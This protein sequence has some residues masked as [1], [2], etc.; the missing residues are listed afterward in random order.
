MLK[1][2]RL[3]VA[4]VPAMPGFY[5]S[6]KSIEELVDMQVMKI[7]DQMGLALPLVKRWRAE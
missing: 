2:A 4:I 7:T 1:L 6:P 5:H 3:G